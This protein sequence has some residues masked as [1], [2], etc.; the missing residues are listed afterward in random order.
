[1]GK[2]EGEANVNKET[3][4]LKDY[5]LVITHRTYGHV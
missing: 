5:T 2:G 4:E 1:M 3:V